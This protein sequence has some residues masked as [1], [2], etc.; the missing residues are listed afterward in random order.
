MTALIALVALPVS[1]LAIAGVLR[2]SL[3]DRLVKTPQGDRW[4]AQPTPIA[5][6]LGIFAGFA[7]AIG[8]ALAVGAVPAGG[9]LL[10][11]LA[12][13]ALLFVAGF[14]DDFRHLSPPAKLAVQFGAA[15]IVVAS[16]TRVEIVSNGAV[17][18]VLALLWLVGMTNAFNLLDN[19]DGLAASL[20]AIAALFFAI[21]AVTVHKSHVALL[22]A[23]GIVFGCLGFLPFNLRP[24][25]G[26]MTYMGDSGSQVLGFA[27]ASLGLASSWKVAGTTVATLILPLL[28]LAV[29]ILDTGLVTVLRLLE[30]RP[31]TEGGRDHSSHRLVRYGLSETHAVLL[32]AVVA[33]GL[34]ST[35]LAY[36]VLDDQRVTLAGLLLTFVALFQFASFLADLGRRPSAGEGFWRAFDVHWRRLVEVVVDFGLISAAFLAAYLVV[37]DGTGTVS[38][39]HM[40]FVT[41]P[42]VIAARYLAFIPFGLYRS[43]WRY[44]G[45]RDVAAIA[46]AV[47]VSEAVALVFVL[48]TQTIGDFDLKVFAVDAVFAVVLI[49]ASRFSE[50]ALLHSLNAR[51]AAARRTLLVGAGR[52]GRSLHRELREM[53]G[54]RVVG[55]LDD[56]P[57]LR[58]RRLQGAPVLGTLLEAAEAVERARPDRV[59]VTIPD[60][61]R[62]RIDAVVDVCRAAGVECGFVRREIALDLP[63]SAVRG[64]DQREA[65]A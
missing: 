56:N 42:A 55:F 33:I 61:P 50:R 10:G 13:C 6:G 30:G 23:L 45:S 24:G 8:L 54:E 59:L 35:S 43:V 40:F 47:V 37:F 62:E 3:R 31:I 1:A 22:L 11:I 19:M 48:L 39:R 21:D 9:E 52:V 29:P 26:A 58:R 27:L 53:P 64:G 17:A 41:L 16:G 28:I 49:T 60:A 7:V 14:V 18:T 12:G 65:H 36:N 25:R 4:V 2:T 32:L 20:A 44:A 46:G 15:G 51:R 57:R 63:L 5:G 38:Q 34:G